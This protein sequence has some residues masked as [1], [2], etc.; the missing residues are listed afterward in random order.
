MNSLFSVKG[1]VALITGASSGIGKFFAMTLAKHGAHVILVG[2]NEDRL[3]ETLEICK[4]FGVDAIYVCADIKNSHDI[5]N[6]ID[7]SK[8]HFSH[9]DIL[10]NTAGMNI[11]APALDVTEEAWDEILDIN[12]KGTFFMTQATAKWMIETKTVGKVVNISSTAAFHHTVIRAPYSASKIAVESLTRTLALNLIEH[13]IR[14]NCIAPGFFVTPINRDH[15]QTEAGKAELAKAPMQ[16][17]GELSELEG[18]LLLLV[19][20]AS[21]Y[22]TG[23]VIQ[24]D[25]GYAIQK[26]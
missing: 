6:I 11:R 7:Q 12:L 16:R 19:S 26:I 3:K 17:A 23:S 5:K 20:N 22:M 25:G 9:L 1:N 2:R 13:K 15:L 14:V 24:V 21:S 8:Q 10:I 18:I 4:K